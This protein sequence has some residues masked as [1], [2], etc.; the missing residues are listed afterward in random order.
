MELVKFSKEE[1]A[2]IVTK[3]Q[4]YFKQ[5]LDF[6]IEQF[7]AEFLLNFISEN[8]GKY[9]YNKGLLDAQA[10]LD[11]QIDEIRES[12]SGLEIPIPD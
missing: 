12:I 10:K 6:E 4:S 5:N 8:I 7:D 11:K 2:S 1:R 9:Y 3:V